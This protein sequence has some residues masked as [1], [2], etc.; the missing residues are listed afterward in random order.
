M[1][2]VITLL[3]FGGLLV[4]VSV[5]R[6]DRGQQDQSRQAEEDGGMEWLLE[7]VRSC[8]QGGAVAA[9]FSSA[10]PDKVRTMAARVLV[11]SAAGSRSGSV[12]DEPQLVRSR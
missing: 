9:S 3:A 6:W 12:G 5:C 1:G 8:D 7:I 2:A 10:E 4:L 11:S